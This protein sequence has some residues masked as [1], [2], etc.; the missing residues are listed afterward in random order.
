LFLVT[1]VDDLDSEKMQIPCWLLEHH[2]IQGAAF[3]HYVCDFNA[4][5]GV[6]SAANI[7]LEAGFSVLLITTDHYHRGKPERNS[8]NDALPW[9]L[10]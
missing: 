3:C 8:V 7:T 9:K 2:S 1:L 5:L 10:R 6:I 4:V